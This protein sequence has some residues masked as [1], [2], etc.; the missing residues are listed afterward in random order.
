MKPQIT[1]TRLLEL[2]KM[3]FDFTEIDRLIYFP[4]SKRIDRREN[5][6]EHSYS[7]AMAAWFLCGYYPHLNKDLVI[8]YSLIHDIVELHA[9]DEMAI[10]RSEKAEQEKIKREQLAL[11]TLEKDWHDFSDMTQLVHIYE[12]RNDAESKFVY[13]L[14]KL[15]PLLLNLLSDGK[16]WKKYKFSRADIF[17]SKD[18][19]I[20]LSPEVNEIWQVF[21]AEL[22]K[23]EDIFGAK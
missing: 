1:A 18:K 14:D 19:K 15:M 22:D 5:N 6:S 9:G 17:E 23:N 13:S 20:V 7:L 16:T 10:G 8:K 21:R 4:D 3:L 2:Q 12:Q 11:Q